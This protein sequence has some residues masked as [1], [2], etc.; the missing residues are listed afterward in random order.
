M[1]PSPNMTYTI[2]STQ[3]KSYQHIALRQPRQRALQS[4]QSQLIINTFPSIV[5]AHLSSASTSYPLATSNLSCA[6]KILPF[7][8]Y[9]HTLCNFSGLDFFFLT[10][11]IILWRV[12]QI[13]C[14]NRLFLLIAG[15]M[16]N[17][18]CYGCTTVCST[19]TLRRE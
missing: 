12:I 16:G 13:V 7:Q 4:L 19:K 14:I 1:Y 8:G 10:L 9:H 5:T 2:F 15:L 6:P 3:R 11:I 18:S 17:I